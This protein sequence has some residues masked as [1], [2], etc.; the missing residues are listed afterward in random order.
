MN[1]VPMSASPYNPKPQAE[2]RVAVARFLK[3]MRKAAANTFPAWLETLTEGIEECL[4]THDHRR[5]ILEIHPLDDYYFAGAVALQAAK[6]WRLFPP[7]AADELLG[8]IAETVDAAA[9][10]TDR[11]VSDLVFLSIGCIETAAATDSQ[12]MAY[13]QVVKVILR[14]LGIDGIEA[15]AHLMTL[16]QFRHPLGEPLALGIPDWWTLFHGKYALARTQVEPQS[17]VVDMAAAAKAV[18]K[19]PP[20]RATAF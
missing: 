16:P 12:K 7:A 2:P 18:R 1:A 14:R 10:R 11:V 19:R 5:S 20:R 15:T 17:K 4:L 6:I 9:D 8:L 3:D 13:D